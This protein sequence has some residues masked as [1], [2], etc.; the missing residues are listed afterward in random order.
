M[1]RIPR[2][3]VR[4]SWKPLALLALAS[5]C[6]FISSDR[7]HAADACTGNAIVCENQKA[8]SPASEWDVAGAGDPTIQGFATDISVDQG[9]RVEFKVDTDATAYHLDIY[10]LGY[11][12]GDGARKVATV[13]PSATLPQSQPP[14]LTDADTGLVDCGN[15]AVSA[16][17]GGAGDAVSGIYFAKLVRDDTRAAPATSSS[18]SATTPDRPTCCSRPPT[19]PGRPTTSTAATAST[20]AASDQ[21]GRAYKVSYNRPFTTRDDA[22]EDWVF[23]AEY[24]MVR[25]L[26]AQR[27][28]RQLLDRRR[29]RPPRSGDSLLEHKVFL[30]VGHDE[31]WS[32]AQRANV[33]AARDAGVNLAFFSGNE[34]FWKT[35]WETSIDGSRHAVPHARLLQGDARERQD[36]PARRHVDRHVARPAVQPAGG[37][38]PARERA[39]RHDLHGQ[40]RRGPSAIQVP[41]ADGK[42]ALLAQHRRRH[43]WRRRSRPRFRPERS[44]T[45]GTRT[46]TT[47]SRPAGS[48]PAVV[49]RPY[50]DRPVPAGLRLDLRRR[51]RDPRADAVPALRAA[52]SSSAPARCS[53]RGAS[54]HARPRDRPPATPAMQQATVTCSPTWASQPLD[55]AGRAWSRQPPSTDVV[56]PDLDDHVAGRRRLG[57]G[58]HGRHDH[59]H[60]DRRGRRRRRRRRGLDR[61]RHDLAP[62][63][64][65]RRPGPTA[66]RHAGAGSAT[67]RSRAVDDSGNLE[68]PV[69][70][71]TVTVAQRSTGATCPCTI[72]APA[73]DAR[74][75]AVGERR[76]A[77]S[78]SA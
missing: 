70:G 66:G 32:G 42:H 59:R 45:S 28:R 23:N 38:R 68:Q 11:Y 12:G 57:R 72:W 77:R 63:D 2:A 65:P 69:G 13:T 75:L 24:P 58:R 3:A 61:R 14:C 52:R 71:V 56:A 19:R 49:R 46:S 9:R 26:E 30:S 37:R 6:L 10:R 43:A 15:W 21:P 48:D 8:G 29:H 18:S 17:V 51:D 22:P 40:L 64:R 74:R 36:R 73:H 16:V 41:A 62:G 44:A 76:A 33:E 67:I 31:Y 25:W 1:A 7:V 5:L 39:D 20:S 27:L 78:S 53:G 55:A 34:I 60:G 54:T 50:D 47:A 4:T 35:R